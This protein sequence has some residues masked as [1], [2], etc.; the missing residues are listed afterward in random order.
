MGCGWSAIVNLTAVTTVLRACG[1]PATEVEV[2][3]V[4]DQDKITAVTVKC[5]FCS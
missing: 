3:T 5:T 4:G 2:R 1:E